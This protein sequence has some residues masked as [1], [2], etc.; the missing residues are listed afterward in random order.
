MNSLSVGTYRVALSW[1]HC[2]T[3]LSGN[4]RF[5][6]ILIKLMLTLFTV[7]AYRFFVYEAPTLIHDVSGK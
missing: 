4:P 7:F 5:F 6:N 3:A 1:L 2:R